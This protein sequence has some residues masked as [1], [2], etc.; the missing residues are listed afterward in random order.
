MGAYATYA[1]S[2]K[3]KLKKYDVNLEIIYTDGSIA[4][5]NKLMNG[6]VDFAFIQSGI[7]QKSQSEEPLV[8]ANVAYEPIWVFYKDEN[9][10]SIEELKNKTVNLGNKNSGSYPIALE[11]MT[12]IDKNYKAYYDNAE[13]AFNALQKGN[14]DAMFYIIGVK[15]SR[16][17]TILHT[18]NIS[19]LN[20]D[21][22]QSYKKFFI[23][24]DE[25]YETVTIEKNSI[26]LIKKIPTTP[27]TLLAKTTMLVTK[28][29][30]PEM[31]RLFLKI[32]K[33]VHHTMGF[34]KCEDT[35]P[36]VKHLKLSQSEASKEY[37]E[38]PKH[39][40]E[41]NTFLKEHYW[42]AQTLKTL[43]DM[44][45]SV[46][47]ILGLVAFFIEVIYP[48]Y[49]MFTRWKINKWYKK[50]NDIDSHIDIL[51]LDEL[52]ER[53]EKLENIL[54]EMQNDDNIKAIHLEAFY[55]VQHQVTNILDDFERRI[56]EKQLK[57]ILV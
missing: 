25:Y 55:S 47:V 24:K 34:I 56:K 14:I 36:N 43:E 32:A 37:F 3:E 28:D 39:R 48:I 54:Q 2:Y 10:S 13:D 22:A 30:S 46:I 7:Q 38:E 1:E 57:E 12:L 27:K 42:L 9:I 45:M 18:P 5:Q 49:K 31:S 17:Q 33:K 11:L 23:Q 8:L 15:S 29:A 51:S 21:N 26:D 6:E 20:F 40:Y 50:V 35:F 53:Q 4:A 41:R 44:I 52:K 19:I 16:L